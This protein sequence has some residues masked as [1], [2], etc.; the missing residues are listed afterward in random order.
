MSATTTAWTSNKRIL[1]SLPHPVVI[2]IGWGFLHQMDSK[3]LTFH[4]VTDYEALLEFEKRQLGQGVDPL[5]V[6]PRRLIFTS[7]RRGGLAFRITHQSEE[8]LAGVLMIGRFKSSA[9]GWLYR[10]WYGPQAVFLRQ[11]SLRLLRQ[12]AAELGMKHILVP[13]N[14]SHSGA[15]T[16]WQPGTSADLEEVE[17]DAFILPDTPSA[18]LEY[19]LYSLFTGRRTG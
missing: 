19:T 12:H 2:I 13:L 8:V 5:A 9:V 14:T 17:Q 7:L 15:Q 10:C 16:F 11:P 6:L 18:E 1:C 3:R 4:T